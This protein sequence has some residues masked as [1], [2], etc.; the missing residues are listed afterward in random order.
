MVYVMF[1][2]LLVN[3][4][5]DVPAVVSE[6][7]LMFLLLLVN[8]VCDVPAVSEWCVCVCDIPAVVSE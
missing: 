8:G 1:L 2:L 3:G 5:C 7:S 6:W 4:V